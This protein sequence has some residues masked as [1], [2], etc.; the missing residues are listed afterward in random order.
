MGSRTWFKVYCNSWL[1]GTIR[2][3]MPEVRAVWIDL[4]ALAG[5]G[6]YGDTG[7]IK[8][9]NGVGFTDAQI[10]GILHIS[11]RLWRRAKGRFIETDRIEVTPKG[12]IHIKNWTKY[13][14]EYRRQKPYR[15]Q[16]LDSS[17]DGT[18][19]TTREPESPLGIPLEIE[20]EIESE[21]LQREVTE[22]SYKE[23]A[24]PPPQIA[25]TND[26]LKGTIAPL[27]TPISLNKKGSKS[28]RKGNGVNNSS[29]G[30]PSPGTP[31][32]LKAKSE[33]VEE[34]QIWSRDGNFT[35]MAG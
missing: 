31:A 27:R 9:S 34:M 29:Q 30:A 3:E 13:Q 1:E 28:V 7:E 14:S 11:V 22:R 8:L 23:V 5:S 12:A 19:N 2:K 25:L 32:S 26:S 4:L 21:K 35:G 10:A 17:I 20:I 15:Q 16:R 24:S 6:Q 33:K 18:R